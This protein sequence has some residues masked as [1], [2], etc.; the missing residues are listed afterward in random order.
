MSV[1]A[2]PSL[3]K[4]EHL[5]IR[6]AA[7]IALHRASLVQTPGRIT[8]ILGP[9][10]AGKSSLLKA[11]MGLVPAASGSIQFGFR[12]ITAASPEIRARLGIAYVPEGR[13]VFPGLTVR[14]NL[15]VAA[16]ASAAERQRRFDRVLTL[17]PPLAPHLGRRAW[18]LS[19][20]QQ[21]MLA[22][23]RALMAAPTMLLL[24][25][26]S[27][28][29]APVLVEQVFARISALALEGTGV[30]LAEQNAAAALAIADRAVVLRQG[31]IVADDS[32]DAIR[33]RPELAESLL[34]A[35]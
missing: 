23:G 4:I 1:P 13:R 20:G 33:G 16:F 22:I 32:A 3:L 27:L 2:P 25:E 17:F 8:A 19:G 31:H 21:Q 30:L 26:P 6:Y 10:G 34:G 18:Q 35:A 12:E 5:S 24:D 9:N 7:T 15:H 28:G 29:L 14:E 11:A